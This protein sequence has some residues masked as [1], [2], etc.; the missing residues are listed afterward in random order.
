MADAGI[1]EAAGLMDRHKRLSVLVTLME[2]SSSPICVAILISSPW[3]VLQRCACNAINLQLSPAMGIA[4][5][6][7]LCIA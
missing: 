2:R 4:C 3:A 1:A 6:H 7:A 5:L